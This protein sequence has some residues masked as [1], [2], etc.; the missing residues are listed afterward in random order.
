[1]STAGF[2]IDRID[3]ST[4]AGHVDVHVRYDGGGMVLTFPE[5]YPKGTLLAQIRL[6]VRA[7]MQG[8]S[9]KARL[10]SLLGRH[11]L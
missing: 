11:D 8:E 9:T 1:M 4:S 10:A 2:L 3:P 6:E 5:S 7:R